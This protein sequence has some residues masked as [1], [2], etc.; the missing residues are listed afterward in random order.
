MVWFLPYF[1]VAAGLF[2]MAGGILD[3]DWFMEN[4]RARLV[5]GLVGRAG[6]RLFYIV[7][8]VGLATFGGARLGAEQRREAD[9]VLPAAK[10][11]LADFDTFVRLCDQDNALGCSSA[12]FL[13]STGAGVAVD[14]ERGVQLFEKG[15]RLGDDQG[16][17]ELRKHVELEQASTLLVPKEAKIEELRFDEAKGVLSFAARVE[18]PLRGRAAL[19]FNSNEFDALLYR[20]QRSGDTVHATSDI[21]RIEVS[22]DGP[23]LRYRWES[24]SRIDQLREAYAALRRR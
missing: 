3:W 8:G 20:V 4:R 9:L 6:A 19:L 2:A 7:L 14:V 24:Q 15:C 12:G 10:A 18:G 22:L 11:P 16:C 23:H 17:R 1:F 13:L 5:V 21:D